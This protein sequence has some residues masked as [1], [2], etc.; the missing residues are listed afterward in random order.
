MPVLVGNVV[1]GTISGIT[2]FGAFVQLPEGKTGLVHIS[3]IS[4]D[5]VN[6]V[7][8]YLKRD[9]KVKVKVLSITNEGK[10]SLSI[11][12]VQPKKTSSNPAQVDFNKPDDKV[13]SMSFEDKVAKFLKDSSEKQEQLKKKDT[14]R[15][16]GGYSQRNYRA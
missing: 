12:Q 3:E 14:R 2:N 10:I 8:D 4:H 15:G 7:S 13:K 16:G 11:R 9:Q 1:E 6:N 5:Y